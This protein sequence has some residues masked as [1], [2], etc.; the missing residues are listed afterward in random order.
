MRIGHHQ[1]IRALVEHLA[2][3][4][5]DLARGIFAGIAQIVQHDR[6]KR[7]LGPVGPDDIDRIFFDRD[8]TPARVGAG[9]GEP[10]GAVDRVQPR[11]I[12]ELRARRQIVFYPG[13]RRLLD[14]MF[15]REQRAVDFLAHLHLI[16][17]VDEQRRAVGQH[18]GDTG[19][20]GEAGEPG[21]P[22]VG[23]RDVFVQIPIGARH[24]KAVEPAAL[25]FRAQRSEAR[26]TCGAIGAIVE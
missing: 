15:D 10:F 6:T 17:A 9:L 11:R 13:V 8:E 14:Q 23:G 1:R 7:R 21:E 19:R 25:E 5:R 16:T 12:A 26:R 4:P 24:H 20:A 2:A 22:L 18:D 3:Q